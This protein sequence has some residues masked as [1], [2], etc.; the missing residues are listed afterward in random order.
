MSRA[1]RSRAAAEAHDGGAGVVVV[2][3]RHVRNLALGL[4]DEPTWAS[5]VTNEQR[6]M[7]EAVGEGGTL[8][9]QGC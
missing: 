4:G 8:Q 9:S 1:R 6:I 2:A 3:P 5:R 7:L